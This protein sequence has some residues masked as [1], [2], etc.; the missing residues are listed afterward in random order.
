[1]QIVRTA[2]DG[3]YAMGTT[4]FGNYLKRVDDPL[5]TAVIT[6]Q[7]LKEFRIRDNL[8]RI[9]CLLWQRWVKLCFHFVDKVTSTTEVSCRFLVKE[10]D[11][12]QWRIAIP[13]Q[14]VSGGHVDAP[15]FDNSIDITTGELIEHWPPAGWIPV[16][17]SHSHNT[18]GVFFSA[19]D[20]RSELGDPGLHCVVGSIN[21]QKNTYAL[22]A[23]ITVGGKRYLIPHDKVIDASLPQGANEEEYQFHPNCLNNV[24]IERTP[25][26][27]KRFIQS[28]LPA[29]PAYSWT[30]RGRTS[31]ATQTTPVSH[32]Y[33]MEQ[34]AKNILDSPTDY[35]DANE[36]PIAEGEFTY[37][38]AVLEREEDI[39]T[40]D[41]SGLLSIKELAAL[42]AHELEAI[43]FYSDGRRDDIDFLWHFA[44]LMR[45]SL[46]DLRFP[47]SGGRL[48]KPGKL[49]ES[50]SFRSSSADDNDDNT[51]PSSIS[52]TK[53]R[54]N[55]ARRSRA[56]K[57][58]GSSEAGDRATAAGD[59]GGNGN[60]ASATRNTDK[61]AG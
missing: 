61:A 16:G 9:P 6:E 25:F 55:P 21:T 22:N 38:N 18:M 42:L 60:A 36:R 58:E 50:K 17:S 10:D 43:E 32:S 57:H 26:E 54:R 45:T 52:S 4:Y 37:Y 8:P 59:E 53:R 51:S 19:T 41:I 39:T 20:D 49:T 29:R 44:G 30:P 24:S 56:V 15:G 2:R 12:T 28:E 48:A 40:S 5:A 35:L 31:Q 47:I 13:P 11:Q 27:V 33:R 14:F 23:S 1:M 7:H 3:C 34:L 46:M